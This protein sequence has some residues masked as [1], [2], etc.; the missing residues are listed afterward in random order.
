[1]QNQE[2]ETENNEIM[3]KSE[4][5]AI[6]EN[7]K[8]FEETQDAQI[9]KGNLE[10]MREGEVVKVDVETVEEYGG[11]NIEEKEV[12]NTENIEDLMENISTQQHIDGVKTE[13]FD[14]PC[15]TAFN[16]RITEEK[17]NTVC[18]EWDLLDSAEVY[19]IEK[20]HRR[21]G[22]QQ[23]AWYAQFTK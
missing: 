11:D 17:L 13:E 14:V 21:Y 4:K 9:N 23:M 19:K 10:D 5:C 7:N 2:S 18:I 22:W 3:E 16:V 1:M 8:A 12:H 20:Y 6:K 15:D